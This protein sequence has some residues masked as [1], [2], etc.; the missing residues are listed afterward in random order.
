MTRPNTRNRTRRAGRARDAAVEERVHQSTRSVPGAET[1]IDDDE[2]PDSDGE[3][4]VVDDASAARPERGSRDRERR[5][6][7]TDRHEQAASNR[8]GLS[9]GGGD[10]RGD[11]PDPDEDAVRGRMR[12]ADADEQREGRRAERSLARMS[13]ARPPTKAQTS[14][15]SR[16]PAIAQHDAEDQDEVRLRR[17][18][19]AGTGRP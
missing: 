15:A 18:R 14:P 12:Q 7:S 4:R 5:T 2:R 10:D 19:S 3:D 13:R 11:G 6:E 17:R 8:A 9:D 16:P 1:W